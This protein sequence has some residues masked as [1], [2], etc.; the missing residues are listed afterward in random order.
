[1]Q[2]APLRFDVLFD[3]SLSALSF[4]KEELEGFIMLVIIIIIVIQL[5]HCVG[6]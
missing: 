6:L 5:H 3:F 2:L 4:V 1:M